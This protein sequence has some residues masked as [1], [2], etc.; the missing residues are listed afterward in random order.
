MK[1]MAR[2]YGVELMA[3]DGMAPGDRQQ[4]NRGTA[5]VNGAMSQGPPVFQG[6]LNA[7]ASPSAWECVG[8][9]PNTLPSK[10]ARSQTAQQEEKRMNSIGLR[11]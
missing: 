4:W 7:A 10:I 2:V 6:G 3:H 1:M 11:P 5:T 9:C 8:L